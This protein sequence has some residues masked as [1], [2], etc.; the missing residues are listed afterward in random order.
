[1]IIKT[2]YCIET[3][4]SPK[5]FMVDYFDCKIKYQTNFFVIYNNAKVQHRT[6]GPSA[7]SKHDVIWT[8]NGKYHRNNGPNICFDKTEYGLV[9]NRWA[10]KGISFLEEEDY[11]NK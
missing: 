4:F 2:K 10:F 1:M 8:L 11:W 7:I 6:K 5:R 9:D 3:W